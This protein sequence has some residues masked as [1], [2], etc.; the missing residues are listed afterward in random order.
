MEEKSLRER[1][2]SMFSRYNYIGVCNITS[3]PFKW[4][5][6]LEQNELM[7]M[8]PADLM[9]EEQMVRNKGGSFLPG[10]SP[11]KEKQKV[12]SYELQPGEK[13]MVPGEAAYVL[14]DKIFRAAIREKYGS[15]KAGLSK[16]V[17]PTYQDEMLPKIMVGPIIKNVGAVLND[18]VD[19]MQDNLEGFSSVDAYEPPSLDTDA[20]MG[21]NEDMAAN[22]PKI[23]VKQPTKG[24]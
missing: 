5:V 15:G 10:D 7:N 24:N 21:E 2:N 3:S 13:K 6:A 20:I 17:V 19:K 12:V 4:T 14:I 9:S 23:H 16:L 18:V 22:Q 11:I 8:G 1:L